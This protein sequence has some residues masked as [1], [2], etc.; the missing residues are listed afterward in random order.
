MAKGDDAVI[1]STAEWT[2]ISR[3][4][5]AAILG[6]AILP[7]IAA[8]SALAEQLSEV[9]PSEVDELIGLE[10]ERA[11]PRRA[12]RRP[13]QPLGLRLA[14]GDQRQAVHERALRGAEQSPDSRALHAAS[15]PDEPS[16]A[17]TDPL[18]G[19]LLPHQ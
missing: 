1:A 5:S 13:E 12:E 3:F 16:R 19:V 4:L 6:L 7:A 9:G 8:E 11:P 14:T 10:W 2:V 17:P 15:T 18:I